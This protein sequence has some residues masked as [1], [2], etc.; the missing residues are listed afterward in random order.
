MRVAVDGDMVLYAV[1]F[2]AK[3]D[4]ISYA[5]TSARSFI[6]RIMH[7][8]GVDGADVYLSGKDNYRAEYGSDVYPYKGNRTQEKPD[9]YAEL[10]RFMIDKL[11]AIETTGEEADD[12]LG[13]DAV[14]HGSII[15]TLDKDLN[16]VPGW[17]YRWG[18]QH[19]EDMLYEVSP[20]DA[21]RFFYQQLITGD[22]T[23]NIPGLFKR[24]GKKATAKLLI[25]IAEMT[26]PEEMYQHVYNVY[27]DA[28]FQIGMCLDEADEVVS[29]WLLKQGRQLWIR[30][31]ENELWSPPS[32]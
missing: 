2:A 24:L 3:D 16:G 17:H 26:Y 6:E 29:D 31:Q 25:P 23:D 10:K 14:Q 27:S 8:L 22:A 32:I 4:P 11:D 18:T 1:A 30:R 21:D 28:Y 19:K 7:R 12:R 20:E 13:I 5:C 15:A 9:H